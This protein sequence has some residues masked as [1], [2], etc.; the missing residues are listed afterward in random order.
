L[1]AQDQLAGSHRRR[2]VG[3][4]EAVAPVVKDSA[5]DP[6]LSC[7]P[8]DIAARVHPFNSLPPKLVAI[9]LPFLSFHFAPPGPNSA[10]E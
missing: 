6:E 7:E 2:R 5:T 10:A 8:D 9:T 4:V 3:L 1:L